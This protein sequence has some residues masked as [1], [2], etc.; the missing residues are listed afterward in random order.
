MK[1]DSRIT[2]LA[3]DE[4]SS[5]KD[6]GLGLA[7][8]VSTFQWESHVLPQGGDSH[9]SPKLKVVVDFQLIDL[10]G[11]DRALESGTGVF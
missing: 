5:L 4:E 1:G 3:G 2:A 10:K 11:L 6:R 7:M 9:R 8:W